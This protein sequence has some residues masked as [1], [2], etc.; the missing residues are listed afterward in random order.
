MEFYVGADNILDNAPPYFAG[1]NGATTG[2]ETASGI[3]DPFGRS[4]YAGVKL[5]F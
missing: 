5:S 1:V 4:Y 3:Y 2:L